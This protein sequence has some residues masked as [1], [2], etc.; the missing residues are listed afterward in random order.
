MSVSLKG[1]RED[2]IACYLTTLL[3]TCTYAHIRFYHSTDRENMDCGK[4]S[5]CTAAWSCEP[6]HTKRQRRQTQLPDATA[7]P[8]TETLE[9]C[10][11]HTEFG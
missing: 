5:T 7:R 11:G 2:Q 8:E 10:P 6:T 1:P 3:P 4:C 9:T